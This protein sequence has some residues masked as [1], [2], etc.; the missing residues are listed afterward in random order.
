MIQYLGTVGALETALLDHNWD[1]VAKLCSNPFVLNIQLEEKRTILHRCLSK[2]NLDDLP[3]DVVRLLVTSENID[4][5]DMF[6]CTPLHLIVKNWGLE[7]V[8]L[9]FLSLIVSD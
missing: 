6:G 4:M 5:Q 8:P 2:S 9:E 7:G 3:L 1:E